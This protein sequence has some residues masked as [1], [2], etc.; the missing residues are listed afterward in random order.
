VLRV[1]FSYAIA[2]FAETVGCYAVATNDKV[3]SKNVMIKTVKDFMCLNIYS[4]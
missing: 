3:A 4:D 2:S 1:P